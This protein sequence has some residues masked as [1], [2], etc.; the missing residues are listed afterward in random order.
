MRKT[1]ILILFFAALQLYA[2]NLDSLYDAY[3]F[4]R[5][6][7][8]DNIKIKSVASIAGEHE[9]CSFGLANEIKLNF[10]RFKPDQQ[11]SLQKLMSRPAT[12]T[13]IASPAGY[14][15]IHFNKSKFPDYIPENIRGNLTPEQIPAYKSLY[16]DSLAIAADSAYN[17]EVNILKYPAP[18]NDGT[19]GGDDK[20]D[21]YIQTLSTYYGETQ[22]DQNIGQYLYT[23][24]M[25]IDDS[26]ATMYTKRIDAAR[27]T[28]AHEF[29]HAIQIGNYGLKQDNS[30][31]LLDV[32]YHELTSTSMEEFVF[33][34]INDYYAYLPYYMRNP[35]RSLASSSAWYD[36]YDVAIWNLFLKARFDVNIIKRIWELMRQDRALNAI[37]NAISEKGSSFK[38]EFAQFGIW[39]YFSG[40]RFL[41]G[42]Y[43]EEAE[44]YPLIKPFMITGF[45]KPESAIDVN[46]EPLSTNFLVFTNNS[47]SRI[48]TFV[49]VIGNCDL[50][51]GINNLKNTTFF[52]YRL[53][54][55][56]QQDFRP[57][58][59]GYYSK[60]ETANQ[61]LFTEINIFNN[62][63]VDSGKISSE[64]IEYAYPQPFK[65]SQNNYI[66]FPVAQD[67][68][69]SAEI[70]IYSI[71]MNL[72]YS[73]SARILVMDKIVVQWN[74]VDSGGRKLGSGVYFYVVKSGDKIKKGKFVILND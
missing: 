14:F 1:Y 63:L 40:N 25:L 22:T 49:A 38:N 12:D 28:V 18:P 55:Q 54:S 74:C 70:Y 17:Y 2:Q 23:S 39:I 9:K 45:S 35:A 52:K 42:K 36:G 33:D 72:V 68:S 58:L 60:V 73:G 16:L 11:L 5:N 31:N 69:G 47:G 19:D 67:L 66:Y 24:Y 64:E 3:L 29:H 34:N 59:D 27:V 32:F 46:S 10:T 21:I 41:P 50:S 30:G 61:F 62:S 13:S 20:Y 53:S 57:V 8:A 56:P 48:D 37:A 15:R 4:M 26:F 65:Y 43:F 7:P 51:N 6:G 71:D 44:N